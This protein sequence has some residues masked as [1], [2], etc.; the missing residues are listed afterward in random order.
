MIKK[1]MICT[2]IA[3]TVSGCATTQGPSTPQ[4][5]YLNR[6][7]GAEVAATNCASAGGY[8]SVA[9]M[10]A[11]QQSNLSKAKKLGATDAEYDQARRKVQGQW[12]TAYIFTNAYQA[13]N[14]LIN[15]V[16][17]AGTAAPILPAK[18]TAAASKSN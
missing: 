4:E 12:T 3:L 14:S 11:D 5:A 6:A 13:C 9:Q 1:F 8:S 15:S 10:R 2:I 17:W 16:A 18:P 7:A